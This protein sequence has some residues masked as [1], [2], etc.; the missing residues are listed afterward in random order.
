MN[1]KMEQTPHRQVYN[2][3]IGLVAPRPI[4]WITSMDENGVLNAAPFSAYNYVCTDPPI[5][6]IG[7]TNRVGRNRPTQGQPRTTSAAPA[8][9]SSTSS[10]ED[11]IEQMNICAT[12]FPAGV[13]ELEMAALSTVPSSVVKV[14][15]IAQ[16]HAAL[17]CR[18][19]STHRN[20]PLPHHPRP[21]RRHVC[22]R[23]VPH[24]RTQRLRPLHQGGRTP[25]YWPHERPRKLRPHPAT[26]S[27][28]S[29]A[30][31]TKNGKTANANIPPDPA[32]SYNNPLS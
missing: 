20:R 19:H 27:S 7:V 11:L 3:L 13:N 31:P 12:D 24:T 4:A 17:E 28:P 16:A 26:A 18:E 30:S 23:P 5:V 15:R 22:R 9:S 10:T 29:P 14:P 21:G 32:P 25:R 2:L 8:S 6:A 1:F